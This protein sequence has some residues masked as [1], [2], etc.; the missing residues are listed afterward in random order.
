MQSVVGMISGIYLIAAL[1]AAAVL[2]PP[3]YSWLAIALLLF[4][5]Y[6][7]CRPPRAGVNLSLSLVALIIIP[8]ILEAT[9][10]G[11]VAALLITPALPFLDNTLLEKATG[12]AQ[13]FSKGIKATTKTKALVGALLAMFAISI[14]AQNATLALAG[15]IIACYLLSL[16]A[17]IVVTTVR[18]P[19]E[20]SETSVRVIAGETVETLVDIRSRTRMSLGLSLCTPYPWAQLNPN[21]LTIRGEARASLVITPRLSGP[22]KLPIQASMVDPHG[23]LRVGQEPGY[24]ELYVIP[25]ARYAGWLA[26]KYLEQTT[27]GAATTAVTLP[28]QAAG[29]VGKGVEYHDSRAY[30]PGDRLKDID[31]THTIKLRELVVKEYAEDQGQVGILLVN[32]TAKDPEEADMV[33]YN[34]ITSALTMAR[35][36]VPAALAAY[37]EEKVLATT[38]ILNPRETVKRALRLAEKVV[39]VKPMERFLDPPEIKRLKRA[40]GQLED[41]GTDPARR[42]ADILKVECVAIGVGARHHPVTRALTEIIE[43][44]SPPATITLVSP[45]NHDIDALSVILETLVG[46]GYNLIAVPI[47][48]KPPKMQILAKHERLI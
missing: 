34:L 29:R 12:E 37:D 25:R 16:I 39:L 21:V 46:M 45:L 11:V 44:V 30:Q 20:I 1:V 42:L 31:W 48:D 9:V 26:K 17:Y 23:L 6:F 24:V 32:L 36:A 19:L 40:I 33:V 27:P 41:V 15:V 8:L 3:F 38:K 43:H 2:S 13:R 22:S 7:I 35:E 4:E 47:A 28:S 10:G 18:A 5:L 14:V